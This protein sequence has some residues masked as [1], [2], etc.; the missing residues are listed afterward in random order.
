MPVETPNLPK[1]GKSATPA[2]AASRLTIPKE[3]RDLLGPAPITEL[4]DADL[5]ER[6]LTQMATA[7]GPQDFVEWIWVKDIVDLAW[8]A[9]RARRAKA[10]CL[11]MARKQAIYE[12]LMA[13]KAGD[14]IDLLGNDLERS[15]AHD[16]HSG[17]PQSLAEFEEILE[18]LGMTQ[19][20][21][22][23]IAFKA[24]ISE[25]ERLQRLV[26]TA[27]TR[28]DAV[29]REIDRRREAFAKLA[30]P[31]AKEMDTIIDAEFE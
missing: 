30:R 20:S 13:D 19:D 25:L 3:T 2:V 24:A 17:D 4:E 15:T 28:R 8:D 29:L 5:Y 10:A 12:I 18:R 31:A 1:G 27:N 21:V 23:D 6:V 14:E 16:I 9:A 11:L 22:M 26:D 7:V